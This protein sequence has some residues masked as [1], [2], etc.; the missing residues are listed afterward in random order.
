MDKSSLPIAVIGAGPVGLAAAAHL[1]RHNM[2]FVVLEAGASAGAAVRQ[3]GHVRLFSPWRYSIDREAAALLGEAGWNTPDPETYPT[4]AE[5]VEHYLEPLAALPHVKPN[6]RFGVLVEAVTREGFDKMKTAGRKDAPFLLHIRTDEGEDTLLARAVIDASG[7]YQ[8]PNPLGSSGVPAPGERILSSHI[9]YGTPD[10]LGAERARYASKRVLVIGSGHSA[11]NALLDLSTLARE[12]PG[13]SIVWA[14]RRSS[15][16]SLYGG[17]SA[18]QLPERARLGAEISSLVSSGA[19]RLITGFKT[20]RIRLTDRGIVV[21]GEGSSLP[22]VDEIIGATGFRPDLDPLRE[23]RL[24]LDATV[25]SPKALAPLIDPNIHS[26]GT[27]PPHGVREL[28]HPE[29]DFYMVGMKSYGRAPTFLMLTGYEQVRS[30]VAALAG[31][32]KAAEQ[33]ELV[34]PET[35]VCSTSRDVAGSCCGGSSCEVSIAESQPIA[36]LPTRLGSKGNGP[37]LAVTGNAS[38]AASSSCD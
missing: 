21:D 16:G 11:F 28:S 36:L 9:T 12:V 27:V 34:L 10:M 17:G 20:Q 15:D 24:D 4:G 19:I 3:W 25:E 31:D 37:L 38:T 32:W 23:L 6:V 7:T 33:V 8:G 26:C 35:G 2:P 18:D 13:T 30:V 1:A 5:L 14:I 29:P 22:P